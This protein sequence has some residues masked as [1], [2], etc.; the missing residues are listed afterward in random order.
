[1][2][3]VRVGVFIIRLIAQLLLYNDFDDAKC[4]L[5]NLFWLIKSKT[6]GG[7]DDGN[8]THLQ[9]YTVIGT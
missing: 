2:L 8:N 7:I 9:V 3:D 1:M 4:F 6:D 5:Q